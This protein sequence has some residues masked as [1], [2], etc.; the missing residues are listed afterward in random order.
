M[1]E[2][3]RNL[4][5][6]RGQPELCLEVDAPDLADR[7]AEG[8][9]RLD[10]DPAVVEGIEAAVSRH[11]VRMGQM[12][13]WLV[14]VLRRRCPHLPLREE[15]GAHG[16]PIAHLPPPSAAARRLLTNHGVAA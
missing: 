8:L 13:Q 10:D 11:L 4:F 5:A 14:E 16:D 2:R 7:I 6:D 15:L 12:G 1:D 3:L 9:Q